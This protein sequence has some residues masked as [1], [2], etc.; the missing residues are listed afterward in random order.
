MGVISVLLLV[1]VLIAVPVILI[2]RRRPS[3]TGGSPAEF[4][5]YLILVVAT[6]VATNAFS[7]LVELALP[8][9][10]VIL[11]EADDLALSLATLL[12]SGVVAFLLWRRLEVQKMVGDRSARSL[13][14]SAVIGF[15]MAVV[16]ASA[17]RLLLWLAGQADLSEVALA[18]LVAFAF[19]WLIHERVRVRG[20]SLDILRSLAGSGV[21]LTLSVTG[22]A[23]VLRSALV[24]VFQ[25]GTLIVGSGAW[26]GVVVGLVLLVVGV[27]FLWWFWFRD[28]LQ[29]ASSGREGYA[30]LVS[31][32][33]WFVGVSALGGLVYSILVTAFGL[34]PPRSSSS[35]FPLQI[36]LSTTAAL[37]YWHHRDVLGRVRTDAVRVLAYLFSS[38]AFVVGAAAGVA[39]IANLVNTLTEGS[40]AGTGARTVLAEVVALGV[41]LIVLWVYWLPSQRLAE[42]PEEDRATIRRLAIIGLLTASA[43]T[44][45]GGLI[46][47]LY[48]LL[49]TALGSV[50]D[51]DT[52][53]L[54]TWSI[55]VTIVT[56][57]LTWYFAAI[58]PRR[59]EPQIDAPELKV[60]TVTVVASDPGPLPGMI[61]KVRLLRRTDSVGV[62][63]QEMASE[64]VAVLSRLDDPAAIVIVGTD[65]FDVIPLA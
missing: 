12:V 19:A 16:A 28:V 50:G 33:A 45:V 58:R 24:A 29:T 36:S 34:D 2:T 22:L 20:A 23:A 26:D 3:G 27:P 48:G 30:T 25:T 32:T 18:D 49:R 44:A 64:I 59:A 57:L 62:V 42:E 5:V 4:L 37:T 9:Q 47:V 63:D 43:V 39:L 31:I 53:D 13:Y 51:A 35:P 38:T 55:P 56:G 15:S 8:S 46:A 54:L 41:A 52:R 11:R 10:N 17:A 1:A 65:S 6:L 21:G 14:V 40:V 7:S 60:S 61:N